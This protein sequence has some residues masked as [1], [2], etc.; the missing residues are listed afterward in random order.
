VNNRRELLKGGLAVMLTGGLALGNAPCKRK[1]VLFI[2]V[3]DLKAIL[4]CYGNEV[5]RTPNI[6]GLAT[7]G[8]VFDRAYCQFPVCN[9]SRS[10]MLLGLRPDRTGIFNNVKSWR[11]TVGDRITLPKL[12]RDGGYHTVGLGKIFHGGDKYDDLS[13]WDERHEYRPTEKGRQGKGRNLTGGTV[14]WCRWLATEGDDEDQPD[15]QLA[16]KA[17][18]VLRRQSNEPFFMAVGFHKPHDPFNAPKK[19]F[20][21]YELGQLQ[22]PAVPEGIETVEKYAIGSGWKTEFDKFSLND[23]REFMRAYYACVTFTDAQI[24]KVLDELDRQRLWENTVVFFVG[25]H[26]YELGEHEWWNKNVLFE[27]SAR[28]P[29]IAVVPGL[30]GSATR[31]KSFVEMVDLYP[32]F[33]DICGLRM[34]EDLDGASFRSLLSE[35]ERKWKTGAFTQV[36]R[37]DVMGKSVRTER[38]RY[39]QWRRGDKVVWEELYDHESDPQEY[40][41]LAGKEGYEGH[42]KELDE[43]LRRGNV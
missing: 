39:T 25:D 20:D 11:E 26:G 18:E 13:A 17:I 22:P 42:V 8:M 9:P 12:F 14:K 6:D 35:P 38:W 5:T 1:N 28:V 16:A 30:T 29:M 7:R 32:T 33:A 31:C 24:G 27:D 40:R 10:S 23:K 37:G 36:T 19:Y 43:L 4:G 15:G 34:P 2:I 3:E 21:M 41:N